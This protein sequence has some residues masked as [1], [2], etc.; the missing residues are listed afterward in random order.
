MVPVTSSLALAGLLGLTLGFG[1]WALV[2]LIPLLNRPRLL[3]RVAPYL[4]DVSP[5]ARELLARRAVDPLPVVGTVFAPVVERM[6]RLLGSTLG[7]S[8]AVRT[9]LRQAG[10]RTSVESF[11]SRQLLWGLG[12]AAAGALLAVG[13]ARAQPTPWL[14]QLTIVA[15]FAV[16]GTVLRDH[17]LQRAAKARLARMTTELPTVLEFLTLSLSAGEGVLDAIR[18]VARISKGELAGELA[19]TV[20]AVNTGLPFAESLQRLGDDLRLPP[21][22]RCIEQVIGALERGTPLAEVLRAQAQDARDEAKRELLETAG[23]KEV[24]MLIPLVFLILPITIV[25]AIYPGI[26]VLQLGF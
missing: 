17:L 6:R 10:I 7:G 21:L 3:H 4:I 15:V 8:D 1:C 14:V 25:F 23:K 18:R 12:G 20:S 16:G 9:R 22:S 11:R 5:G 19:G 13:A 2:S 26:F 24:A